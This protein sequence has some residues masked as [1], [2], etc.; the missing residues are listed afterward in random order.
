ML[1]K[2]QILMLE[3]DHSKEC[4][5]FIAKKFANIESC[6]QLGWYFNLIPIRKYWT[7]YHSSAGNIRVSGYDM[8]TID[9]KE[10]TQGINSY[11]V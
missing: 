1:R 2:S 9:K 3:D 10:V 6:T 5:N 11:L 7:F 8:F 4:G